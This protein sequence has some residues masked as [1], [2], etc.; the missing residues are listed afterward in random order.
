MTPYAFASA[1]A[2][3]V[4]QDSALQ[5]WATVNFSKALTCYLGLPSEIFP[6]MEDDAP[7]LVFGDPGKRSGQQSRQVIYSL[8]VWLGLGIGSYDVTAIENYYEPDGV[9][10]VSAGMALVLT[11]IAAAMP[12]NCDIVEAGLDSDTMGAH[13]EV[14]GFMSL[15]FVQDLVIGQDPLA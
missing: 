5:S 2:R 13:D 3:A 10:L 15:E 6:K 4:A 9:A 12:D 7:F 8:D 1:I 14:H 11:A